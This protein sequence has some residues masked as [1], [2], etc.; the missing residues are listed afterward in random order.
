M[1]KHSF[2]KKK[3]NRDWVATLL[4]EHFP[5]FLNVYLIDII[6]LFSTYEII[7]PNGIQEFH[8]ADSIKTWLL[9]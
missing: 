4:L 7:I 8:N 1:P 5:F 9:G 6:I 3:K 2:V